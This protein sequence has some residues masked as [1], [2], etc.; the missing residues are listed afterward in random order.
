MR[1]FAHRSAASCRERLLTAELS[2]LLD[3]A[4]HPPAV[5]VGHCA[6]CGRELMIPCDGA[7]FGG[8]FTNEGYILNSSTVRSKLFPWRCA[9][10]EDTQ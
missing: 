7:D 10:C 5:K 9:R 3:K 4:A 8:C 6:Q 2:D 1:I